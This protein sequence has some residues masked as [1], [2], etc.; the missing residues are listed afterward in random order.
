MKGFENLEKLS[1]KR[2]KSF[3]KTWKRSRLTLCLFSQVESLFFVFGLSALFYAGPEG[4]EPVSV[5][6]CVDTNT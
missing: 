3:W 4:R 6:A 5:R 2:K 1:E